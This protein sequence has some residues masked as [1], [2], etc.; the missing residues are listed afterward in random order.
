MYSYP[1]IGESGDTVLEE[2]PEIAPN[3]VKHIMES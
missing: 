3:S 2:V 1:E